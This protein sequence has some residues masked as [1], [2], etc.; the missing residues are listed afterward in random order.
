MIHLKVEQ[1]E[2]RVSATLD[3]ETLARLGAVT[4][5]IVSIPESAITVTPPQSETDR[6]LALAR[7]AMVD[8]RE[9]L[10]TLAQ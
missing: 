7:E 6:Q 10:I 2:G 3:A 4:G 8:Y 5:G 1:I 9:T